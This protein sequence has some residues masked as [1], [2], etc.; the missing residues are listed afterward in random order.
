M[1]ELLLFQGELDCSAGQ[2]V[3]P[4]VVWAIAPNGGEVELLTEVELLAELFCQSVLEFVGDHDGVFDEAAELVESE[5]AGGLP[6]EICAV[7]LGG[8]GK[9]GPANDCAAASALLWA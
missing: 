1:P 5:R 9:L 2:G 6:E 4:G 7:L 8:A 3:A